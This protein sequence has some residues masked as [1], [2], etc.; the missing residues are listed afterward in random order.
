MSD[1][2]GGTDGDWRRVAR[3]G[4]GFGVLVAGFVVLGVGSANVVTRAIETVGIANGMA[5]EFGFATAAAIPPIVLVGVIASI[6]TQS[7][8]RRLAIVGIG[9][10]TIGIAVG[11][12]TPSGIGDPL[13]TGIYGTGIAMA[14]ATLF[15]GVLESASSN[16]SP[17]ARPTTEYRREA[18]I[19]RT[20]PADGGSEDDDLSFF[21]D[22]EE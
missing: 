22:D 1:R 4:G 6:E 11:V 16:R 20:L 5:R 10:A 21:L 3:L 18:P 9:L 8:Y 19:D 15:S 12:G 17:S 7:R 13:V 2:S 14:V